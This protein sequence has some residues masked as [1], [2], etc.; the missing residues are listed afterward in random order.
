MFPIRLSLLPTDKK[1]RIERIKHYLFLKHLIQ[2]LMLCLCMSGIALL[3]GRYVLEK[4]FIQLSESINLISKEATAVNNEVRSL[5]K[6]VVTISAVQTNFIPWSKAGI[7][8]ALAT[9]GA[10]KWSSWHFS[11]TNPKD[12]VLKITGMA[13]NRES[14]LTLAEN[15]RKLPWIKTVDVPLDAIVNIGTEPFNIEM[16]FNSKSFY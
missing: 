7:E 15:L 4:N 12:G 10:V 3:A 2:I 8:I 6:K 13:Q 16:V 9:P 11:L 14:L 1:I 5:N